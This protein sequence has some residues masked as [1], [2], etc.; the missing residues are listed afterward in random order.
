MEYAGRMVGVRDT[1]QRNTA[2][3]HR[4]KHSA[5]AEPARRRHE[6][7][8]ENEHTGDDLPVRWRCGCCMLRVAR[9]TLA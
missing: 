5:A 6:A 1:N 8:E 3:V 7:H 4:D 9:C 2:C